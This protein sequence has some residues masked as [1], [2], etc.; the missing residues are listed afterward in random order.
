MFQNY[1]IRLILLNAIK[2]EIS[3][4]APFFKHSTILI[5]DLNI[6]KLINNFQD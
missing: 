6:K 2:H 1:N 4:K 3:I 5:Y